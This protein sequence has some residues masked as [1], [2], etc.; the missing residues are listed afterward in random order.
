MKEIELKLTLAGEA[1]DAFRNDES[2]RQ[3]SLQPPKT[4]HLDNQ[5]FDT[6]D[7]LL[8][9][10][11]AALRIRKTPTQYVQTL[12][13]KG[14]AIAG[15]H[16]R[17]E[18]ES[19]LHVTQG[20]AP[21]LDWNALPAEAR[22]DESVRANIQPLFKTDFQRTTWL[23][24]RNQSQIEL[25]LDEGHISRGDHLTALCEIEL[26]LKAGQASDLFELALELAQR[27]P[28][29]P[30]DV[31]KAERGYQLMNPKL[32]FF[33]PYTCTL[34]QL[35]TQTLLNDALTRVSRR[36]DDFVYSRNWWLLV[37]I[38]REVS[39]VQL[40]LKTVQADSDLQARWADV[41]QA[42]NSIIKPAQ[43]PVGLFVDRNNNSLGLSQR[44][45]RSIDK[46]IDNQLHQLVQSNV[47][48][49]AI[50]S[51]GKHLFLHTYD[52][53]SAAQLRTALNDTAMQLQDL[54]A[55]N[56]DAQ[57]NRLGDMQALA[58]VY[59]RCQSDAYDGVN[60]YVDQLLIV[61]GMRQANQVLPSLQD[62]D[63]RAKLASWT[64]RIT[65]ELRALQDAH[66]GLG[67]QN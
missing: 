35:D 8:N 16:Q 66:R 44:I 13:N 60:S 20:Q 48:G 23:L 18:W 15:L 24:S 29:V 25:V 3:I 7:L 21:Q 36:W 17:G 12:K 4:E 10:S 49:L 11:H 6:P 26:E 53:A 37:V 56:I 5:Y 65:V 9:Q 58:Y 38:Q 39:A 47:L 19:P 46:Y 62:Q 50:L 30:C 33:Q 57:L 64:R 34:D 14:T 61:A 67:K 31:N 59:R 43:L 27:F 51:L 40:V 28:L 55:T 41:W 54:D 63:S 22:P 32:S 42:L 52:S 45:L 1:A 2:L